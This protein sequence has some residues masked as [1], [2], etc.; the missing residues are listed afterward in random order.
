MVLLLLLRNDIWTHIAEWRVN[1]IFI[2]IVRSSISHSLA[3]WHFA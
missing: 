3:D 1:A 2:Q